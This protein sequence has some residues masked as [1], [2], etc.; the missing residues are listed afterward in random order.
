MG[1]IVRPTHDDFSVWE[2]IPVGP[3]GF[4]LAEYFLGEAGDT[5]PNGWETRNGGAGAPTMDYAGVSGFRLKPDA[6][7]ANVQAALRTEY[8]AIPVN[9]LA[10]WQF[11]AVIQPNASGATLDAASDMHILLSDTALPGNENHT[12]G[13]GGGLTEWV[14][15]AILR[16]TLDLYK[17]IGD[18]NGMG[19]V[20]TDSG[21]NMSPDNRRWCLVIDYH[22]AAQSD[23]DA[24]RRGSLR[25]RVGQLANEV[26]E[27][28]WVDCGSMRCTGWRTL[29]S[30]MWNLT[31][32]S[33]KMSGTSTDDLLVRGIGFLSASRHF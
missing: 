26:S 4:E 30:D 25:F 9:M 13:W 23:Y 7:D 24:S 12:D 16:G 17:I 15:W 6:G 29:G 28:A 20:N 21:H 11:W 18:S 31:V 5:L 19:T 22:A 10:D 32:Q 33:R 2:N 14:G 3:H 1:L 8:A 27:P